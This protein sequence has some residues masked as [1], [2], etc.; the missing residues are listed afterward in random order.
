LDALVSSAFTSLTPRMGAVHQ[1]LVDSNRRRDFVHHEAGTHLFAASVVLHNETA[2]VAQLI[3]DAGIQ[4]VAGAF[5]ERFGRPIIENQ[6]LGAFTNPSPAGSWAAFRDWAQVLWQTIEREAAYT[7]NLNRLVG[8]VFD[9]DK[10]YN[11]AIGMAQAPAAAALVT[12]PLAAFLGH[13]KDPLDVP[14][15]GLWLYE[16]LAGAGLIS[17]TGAV[18]WAHFV[19][20]AERH[21]AVIASA[22]G[23]STLRSNTMLTGAMKDA[24]VD[25]SLVRP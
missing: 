20:V 2:A 7:N 16:G 3:L 10:G 15:F 19:V 8:D 13:P 6:Q 4:A 12:T 14:A 18:A 23:D 11:R 25:M 21:W 24:L 9:H 22:A 1:V 17:S 5:R